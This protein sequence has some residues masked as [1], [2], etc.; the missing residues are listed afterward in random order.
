MMKIF[1]KQFDNKS[2]VQCY[3]VVVRKA[4]DEP[5]VLVVAGQNRALRHT[6]RRRFGDE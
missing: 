5:V 2:G 6:S 4:A 3:V 1:P